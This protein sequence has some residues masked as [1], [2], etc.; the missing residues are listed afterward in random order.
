MQQT[1]TNQGEQ[2]QELAPKQIEIL[3]STYRIMGQKGVTQLALQDVAEHAGVSK[4]LLLYHFGT[5]E[6]LILATLRWV[7]NGVAERIHAAIAPVETA[8]AKLEAMIDS[9]FIDP[10]RNREFY[11]TYC[12]L[13]GY[14]ARI[15]SFSEVNRTFRDTVNRMYAELI[16]LGIHDGAFHVEDVPAAA[17]VVRALIDG[18]FIQ[19]LQERDWQATHAAYRE[20]CKRSIRAYLQSR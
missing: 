2:A 20:L 13:L 3:R 16:E 6:K 4:A 11:L 12:D 5:K 8:E 14:A 1:T 17:A 18:L 19:W 7:L 15:D 9:I 10:E